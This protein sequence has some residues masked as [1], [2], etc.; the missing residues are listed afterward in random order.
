VIIVD[1]SVK[2]YRKSVGNSIIF[3]I[4]DDWVAHLYSSL[5]TQVADSSFNMVLR[6]SF[7][8]GQMTGIDMAKVTESSSC[9]KNDK[10]Y[11]MSKGTVDQNKVNS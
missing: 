8:P 11:T 3:G 7:T 10:V 1:A 4:S 5:M 2:R 6:I 9:V